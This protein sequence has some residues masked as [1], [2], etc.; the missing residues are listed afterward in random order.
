MTNYEKIVSKMSHGRLAEMLEHGE[1]CCE[2]YIDKNFECRVS[3]EINC[4]DCIKE[5]LDKEDKE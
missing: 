5:W 2:T 3:D 4:L 1:F